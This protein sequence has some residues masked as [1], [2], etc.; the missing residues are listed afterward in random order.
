VNATAG[1]LILDGSSDPIWAMY[2]SSDG[3]WSQSR[4]FVYGSQGGFGYLGAVDDST[5]D[6]ASGNPYRSWG[7]A[8][9]PVGFAAKFGFTSVSAVQIGA[10]GSA[11]RD[12]GLRVT[13]VLN[14][15]TTTKQFT[16][17]D[18]RSRLGIKSPDIT[19]S[20][21]KTGVTARARSYISG[22]Q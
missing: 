16:G 11:N 20:W 4:A 19:I 10:Q 17:S 18:V 7:A 15:R 14:G 2:S 21:V 3:G 1:E 12:Q 5:W 13:G 9:T 22:R 8:Y 6:L